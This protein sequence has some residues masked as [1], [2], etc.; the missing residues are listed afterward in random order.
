[1]NLHIANMD[2]EA[3]ERPLVQRKYSRV[4]DRA[5]LQIDEPVACVAELWRTS[6]G[7]CPTIITYE[8][9]ISFAQIYRLREWPALRIL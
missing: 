5:S 9:L 1:M 8:M 4:L 2:V 3:E 7:Q 6:H